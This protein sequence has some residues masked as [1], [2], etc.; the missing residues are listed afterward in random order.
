MID[1]RGARG[2]VVALLL[3]TAQLL[4]F[5]AFD[6][7]YPN[8]HDDFYTAAFAPGVAA[9]RHGEPAELLRAVAQA[10][11]HPPLAPAT[12]SATLLVLGPSRFAFRAANLPWLLLL[13][14]GT[15]LLARDLIG[16]S[17]ADLSAFV[18]A[19]LPLIIQ[20]SRK[21]DTQF[22][23]ASLTP[24]GLWLAVRALRAPG[25]GP[26]RLWV[27]L[28]A[29][30]ALRLCVHPI[31]VPDVA[32]TLLAVGIALPGT[33]L[34][35]GV[36]VGARLGRWGLAAATTLLLAG[37]VLGWW[38][39][40]FGRLPWSFASYLAARGSYTRPSWGD[41]FTASRAANLAASLLGEVVW[42]HVL[43]LAALALGVGILGASPALLGAR[44][45]FE[46]GRRVLV[47][48]LLGLA[49]AELPAIAIGTSHKAFLNDWL[50]VVP[51]IVVVAAAGILALPRGPRRLASGLL[52]IQ[53][54]LVLTVPVAT[55]LLAPPLARPEGWEPLPL[56]LLARATSGRHHNSH[57]TLVRTALAPSLLAPR[58][59]H[60]GLEIYDL[61]WNP[62]EDSAPGCT[63]GRVDSD[64][65][66]TWTRPD[67]APLEANALSPWPFVFHDRP[68][69][70]LALPDLGVPAPPGALR[71]VRVWVQPSE[72]WLADPFPCSVSERLPEGFVGQARI[73]VQD[74]LGAV[75]EPLPDP[76]QWLLSRVVEWD[77]GRLY[78]H[79]A[80]VVGAGAD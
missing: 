42:L 35:A 27:G 4:G 15:W 43:P 70:T 63:L 22:H 74:R 3:G 53:G 25:G 16:R 26:R 67:A 58:T 38:P 10:P 79:L 23:A 2:L 62:G 68:I 52:L 17:A 50:F 7:R 30:Q 65:A 73:R 46:G 13:I 71:I 72:R 9:A 66:W 80:F 1:V 34:G 48:G 41:D 8:D 45:G 76:T 57:H 69:P 19:T 28:G 18:V 24:F 59:P 64:D 14:T 37:P 36:R 44:P 39:G 47:A 12:L 20:A 56:R 78:T 11:L 33:A 21:W 77:R 60:E 54:L 32:V 49:I 40:V 51:G 75:A 61:A 55:S 29:W 5:A 6:G 31:V